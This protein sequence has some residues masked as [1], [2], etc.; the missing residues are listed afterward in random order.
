MKRIS[1][2]DIAKELNLSTTTVSFVV[3]GKHKAMGISDETA[4]RVNELVEKRG[5]NPNTS[6]RTL[7]TG[8]SNTIALI[9]EDISN[10]FFASIAKG[11]ETGAH[12][13]S[14]K[15]FYGSTDDNND[16]AD[17]L[18]MTMKNSAVDGFIIT[19]TK[20]MAEQIKKLKKEHIPFILIDRLIQD[21]ETDYVILDNHRG[22]YDLT[23]HL[24]D[25]GYRKIG[26]VTLIGGM[27]QMENRKNGFFSALNDAQIGISENAV[28]EVSYQDTEDSIIEA[29]QEYLERNKNLDALFFATNYLGISG[30]EAIQKNN[31]TIP[32][33]IAVVSFDDNVLFRLIVPSIT[34]AAQ[35]IE[36]IATKSIELLLKN[37]NKGKKPLKP[38][39]IIIKPEIIIR[40]SSAQKAT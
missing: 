11:I 7:R 10:T 28:L 13:N 33:D 14:Y 5:Y 8:K 19:P 22:A 40:N 31:L 37:I 34:V 26:F 4:Q 9:V 29:I 15:I 2:Q 25:N 36:E 16:I 6:A 12:K 18:F 21:I 30:L 17:A 27:S 39:G 32:K 38:V 1:I 20:G 24:I 3:N 35:P 23:K